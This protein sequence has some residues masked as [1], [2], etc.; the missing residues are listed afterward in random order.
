[1]CRH[2]LEAVLKA[3]IS[4]ASAAQRAGRAGRVRAGHCFR[5]CTE[6]DYEAQLPEAT[7]SSAAVVLSLS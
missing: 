6:A 2:G 3:P 4:K 1:M 5:L 7:V